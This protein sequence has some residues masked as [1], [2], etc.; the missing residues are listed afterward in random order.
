[1]S[2]KPLSI[3]E[4][5]RQNIIDC[6]IRIGVLEKAY[7]EEMRLNSSL[8]FTYINLKKEY[9]FNIPETI[10]SLIDTIRINVELRKSLGFDD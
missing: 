4:M 6:V 8:A 3:E 2:D 7:V 5:T 1:M 9:D 10:E